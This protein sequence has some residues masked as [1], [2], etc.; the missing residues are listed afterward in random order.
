MQ[1]DIF[2]IV[3]NYCEGKIPDEQLAKMI[4]ELETLTAP[5]EDSK[6]EE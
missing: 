1:Q 6:D 3:M 4:E 5:K 2:S